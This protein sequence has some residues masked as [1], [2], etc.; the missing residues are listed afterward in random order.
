M[1]EPGRTI[2]SRHGCFVR[3]KEENLLI[4]MDQG[5]LKDV[6]QSLAFWSGAGK[7][8][9]GGDQHYFLSS[10]L[11][12]WEDMIILF[13]TFSKLPFSNDHMSVFTHYHII[14]KSPPILLL[15]IDWVTIYLGNNFCIFWLSVLVHSTLQ[16]SM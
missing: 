6:R 10:S 8:R 3:K 9:V 7:W 12:L 11:S 5:H 15:G 16:R 1:E 13:F 2:A 14:G 4:H